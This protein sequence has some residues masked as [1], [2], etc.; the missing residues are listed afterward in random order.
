MPNWCNNSITISGPTETIQQLWDDA[1]AANGLLQ[2]ISPMPAELEDTTAPSED[3]MD[4][5]SWRVNTW[6]TK[7]DVDLEG[8]EFI[9]N[10]DGTAH[11]NGWF[12]SAW[13]PPIGAYEQLADDF[14]SCVVDASYHEPGMDFAGFWSSEG[15]DEFC[16]DLTEQ[17]ELPE[18]DRS[19]LFNRLDEEYALV[20]NYEMWKEE[21][22]EDE[23]D[24]NSM[25]V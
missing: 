18:D 6:G 11:I 3:G 14:D 16:E 17:C 25:G 19:D 21:T 12:D 24:L 9:N 8:L 22:E 13:A 20:E 7:W 2:A 15:G 4:W 23:V 5:Y 10:E 1:Q